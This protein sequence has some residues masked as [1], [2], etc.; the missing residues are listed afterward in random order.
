MS[1]LVLELRRGETMIV[2][3]APIRFRTKTRL[4]LTGRARF[5]FG[6]QIMAPEEADTP[7]RRI[8]LA[9]Q[10][11]YVGVEG[12]RG[13]ELATARELVAGFKAGPCSATARDLV[14]RALAAAERDDCYAALKLV[15]QVIREEEGAN[16]NAGNR[17]GGIRSLGAQGVSAGP[18]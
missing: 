17:E 15:R 3:G 4:E 12:M 18:G 2:N 6:N 11:A 14:D 5:L 16:L 13:A 10:C 9:L 1:T 7:A 8:Y